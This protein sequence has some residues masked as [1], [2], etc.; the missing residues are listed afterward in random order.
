M[1]VGVF[2][3]SV[4]EE[5]KQLN[6]IIAQLRSTRRV[7]K[8]ENDTI[9]A[10]RNQFRE[11]CEQLTVEIDRVR[12][13]QRAESEAAT[14]AYVAQL[15]A[16]LQASQASQEDLLRSSSE[17]QAAFDVVEKQHHDACQEL[18]ALSADH[19]IAQQDLRNREQ[20]LANMMSIVANVEGDSRAAAARLVR[21][22]EARVTALEAGAAEALLEKTSACEA[23][24]EIAGVSLKE[25]G[26]K[27]EIEQL[28]RRKAEVEMRREKKRMEATVETA[29]RQLKN[30]NMEEVVDRT[31][32]ANLITT[33]VEQRRFV[34]S[35]TAMSCP[36][37][38]RNVCCCVV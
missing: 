26:D 28:L 19:V 12:E 36:V 13:Q 8:D 38:C 24:L 11:Q 15:Q 31:L 18:E 27:L 32:I 34:F 1:P 25:L 29:L 10:E 30:T 2:N 33:Y 4:E 35:N 9:L 16:S 20:E 3:C 23:Q 7:N 6:V 14:G 37:S 5:K 17:L 22:H 21:E